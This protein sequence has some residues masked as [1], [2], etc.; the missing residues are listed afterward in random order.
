MSRQS[1]FQHSRFGQEMEHTGQRS[2]PSGNSAN[3]DGENPSENLGNP[4]D[5]HLSWL[6]AA[7]KKKRNRHWEQRHRTTS[8]RG[9][10]AEINQVVNQIA[11]ELNISNRDEVARVFL[12]YGL[13]CFQEGSLKLE[14][15]FGT[16]R[17]TLF[18][19][20]TSQGSW[21][22]DLEQPTPPKAR[23]AKKPSDN[24]RAWQTRVH[25][26]LPEKLR[27]AIRD[28]ACFG[29]DAPLVPIG[30][31]VTSFFVRAI[32]D[33]QRGILVLDPVPATATMT[34]FPKDGEK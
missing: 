12:E 13:K 9:V 20:K 34:L 11:A 30:E 27:D 1:A 24:K 32:E 5:L 3:A 10:P 33:Y 2:V 18:P 21:F 15:S 8:Y 16:G 6:P 26:R 17:L 4:S 31:V 23:K 14:P 22:R 19:Y 29:D 25:Y 28:T 7:E